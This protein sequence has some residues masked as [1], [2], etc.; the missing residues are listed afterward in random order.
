MLIQSAPTSAASIPEQRVPRAGMKGML[1]PVAAAAYLVGVV[2]LWITLRQFGDRWWPATV[3]LLGPRWPF[4][5]PLV[6]LIP[7]TLAERRWRSGILVAVAGAMLLWGVFG[8]RLSLSAIGAT[9]GDVRVLTC[10]GH[11]QHL[12]AA[13]LARYLENVRPDVV[14]I[15]GWSEANQAILFGGQ[16]WN[17]QRE[18][19][20]LLASRFP[21]RLVRALDLTGSNSGQPGERGAAAVFEIGLP[22]RALTLI[23]LHLASPHGGLLMLSDDAGEKLAGNVDRRW[24]ETGVITDACE[25]VRGPLLVVGDFNTTDDSPMFRERWVGQGLSDAFGECGSGFGYTYLIRRTQLRI[26]HILGNASIGFKRCWVGPEVGSPH[27]PLVA[28]VMC[29]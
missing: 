5:I 28:D 29:R 11:R 17:T 6:M 1:L 24:N 18:G 16:G 9:R 15:Q 13:R 25:E 4:A 20:L 27:R 22:N 21:I 3:L 7:W 26:D 10:N 8:F 14:A 19:E 12:D 2:A 23:N